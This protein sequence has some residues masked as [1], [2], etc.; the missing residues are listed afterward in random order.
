MDLAKGYFK[1]KGMKYAK[2]V[3]DMR[4]NAWADVLALFLL[5]KITKMHCVCISMKTAIGVPC[6]KSQTIMRTI[7]NDAMS[8]SPV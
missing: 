6:L 4:S 2:W 7:C 1:S 5:S 3:S 8:T